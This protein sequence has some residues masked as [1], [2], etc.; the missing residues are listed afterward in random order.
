MIRLLPKTIAVRIVLVLLLGLTVTHVASMAIYYGDRLTLR[1][2]LGSDHEAER[3]AI[4]FRL[5]NRLGKAERTKIVDTASGPNLRLSLSN[6]PPPAPVGQDDNAALLR[7]LIAKYLGKSGPDTTPNTIVVR[8]VSGSVAKP[9][10]GGEAGLPRPLGG[11]ASRSSGSQ[12]A[13]HQVIQA[14]IRLDDGSW[15]N[16]Q[17][18]RNVQDSSFPMR[19]VLSTALMVLAVIV[20]GICAAR[21]VNAPLAAVARAAE[22]LG[23]DATMAKLQEKGP[24]EVQRMARAFNQMQERIRNFIDDRTKMLAAISH[25]LRTPITRLRLRAEFIE[26][27]GQHDKTLADLNHMEKMISSV[28]SFAKDEHQREGLEQIDLAALLLSICS[29]MS[30]TGHSVEYE[31]AETLTVMG[32]PIALKRAFTNLVENAVKYGGQARV[33]LTA[34]S[35]RAIVRIEDDGPG[36]S[37][38]D[39]EKV[40]APFF[41]I[42]RARNLETGGTGLGLALAR[43]IIRAHGGDIRLSNLEPKGLQ[44][45]VAL[46]T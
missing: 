25:D 4:L 2:R 15:L 14:S 9:P 45:E 35:K 33:R 20:A 11:S 44:V 36:I 42:D 1:Q 18:V 23:E 34:E 27:K 43:S 41:R 3:I 17:T 39:R 38:E 13:R 16:Y 31:G 6:Q 7:D 29:D 19:L 30:D 37:E 12:V 28:L 22:R 21:R 5:V 32:R 10:V 8:Y 46:P 40:F 24:L 26:D